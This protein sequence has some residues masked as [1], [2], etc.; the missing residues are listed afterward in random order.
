MLPDLSRL[1]TL[2][3]L[4]S[5]LAA[6]A[7]VFDEGELPRFCVDF[8]LRPNRDRLGCCVALIMGLVGV[9]GAGGDAG[10]GLGCAS[11]ADISTISNSVE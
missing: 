9:L 2:S 6:E 5:E 8:F 10:A 1:S 11:V 7:R 4:L 3:P